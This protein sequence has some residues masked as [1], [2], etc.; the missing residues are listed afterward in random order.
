MSK[1]GNGALAALMELLER[2]QHDPSV[3]VDLLELRERGED[4]GG[5]SDVLSTQVGGDHYKKLGAYQPWEVLARWLTSDELR[6]FAKG[7]AIAYMAREREKGGIEDIEK[8]IHTLQIYL[9][10]R[11]IADEG[12]NHAGLSSSVKS[13][14]SHEQ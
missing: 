9:A 14:G 8:A 5:Q 7:T 3:R 10:L 2:V 4:A 12:A 1:Q 11:R 13:G 6:G